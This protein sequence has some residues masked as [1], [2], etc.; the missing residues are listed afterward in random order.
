MCD[1]IRN[2][3]VLD[4]RAKAFAEESQLNVIETVREI[5]NDLVDTVLQD[6]SLKQ[7]GNEVAPSIIEANGKVKK[8][9]VLDDSDPITE[10]ERQND[11]ETRLQIL[12]NLFQL[13]CSMVHT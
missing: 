2:F 11:R 8:N 4:Y 5:V 9:V 6:V 1:T 12:L 10:T 13:A 7:D 3:V